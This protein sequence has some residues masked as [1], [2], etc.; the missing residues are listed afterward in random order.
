[1]GGRWE[2]FMGRYEGGSLFLEKHWYLLIKFYSTLQSAASYGLWANCGVC[3]RACVRLRV[4]VG[5]DLSVHDWLSSWWIIELT[6]NVIWLTPA[7]QRQ[8]YTHRT[9]PLIPIHTFTR[10]NSW[11]HYFREIFSAIHSECQPSIVTTQEFPVWIS[12]LE[13]SER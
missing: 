5:R 13:Q 1:M 6:V 3:V 7:A 12:H 11:W 9:W 2:A 4:E 8:E 10:V